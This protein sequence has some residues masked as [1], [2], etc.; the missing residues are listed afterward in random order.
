VVLMKDGR[1]QDAGTVDQLL[2]RQPLFRDMFK[3]Y[4]SVRMDAAA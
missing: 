2:E 3:G 4:G 1:V